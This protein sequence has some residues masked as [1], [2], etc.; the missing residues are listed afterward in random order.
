MIGLLIAIAYIGGAISMVVIGRIR[1]L[2]GI[3]T[4]ALYVISVAALIAAA[5]L[6]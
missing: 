3:T 4:P 1:D 2:T 5:L 6:M